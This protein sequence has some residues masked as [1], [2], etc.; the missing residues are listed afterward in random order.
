[1]VER[2]VSHYTDFSGIESEFTSPT[3]GTAL[4]YVKSNLDVS[5]DL[6]LFKMQGLCRICKTYVKNSFLSGKSKKKCCKFCY[7]A[8]CNNC[9]P[10]KLN[11]PSTKKNKRLC[12]ACFND[13]LKK[14]YRITIGPESNQ[15]QNQN[16]KMIIEQNHDEELIEVILEEI[17]RRRKDIE[18]VKKEIL[19]LTEEKN[20]TNEIPEIS[21]S[22]GTHEK[23]LEKLAED[24]RRAGV[25]FQAAKKTVKNNRSLI[26]K[27]QRQAQVFGD[28]GQIRSDRRR[29]SRIDLWNSNSA[30]MI[31][32]DQILM[33]KGFKKSILAENEKLIKEEKDKLKFD[34]T[35]I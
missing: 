28:S 8:V 2:L 4:N 13:T 21:N 5:T 1:M 31:L 12:L 11:D 10:F 17:I 18:N 23:N 30:A 3:M 9:S 14:Y 26:K 19:E 32:W 24:H 22:D 34:C 15:V 27:L 6:E 20:E 7:Q 25:E 16:L 35:I 33:L 29:I